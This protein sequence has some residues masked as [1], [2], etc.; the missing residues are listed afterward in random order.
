[1]TILELLSDEGDGLGQCFGCNTADL[2]VALVV[3]VL[4]HSTEIHESTGMIENDLLLSSPGSRLLPA[5]V[6]QVAELFVG[7]IHCAIW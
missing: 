6:P 7:H 2:F 3:L 1:M 4:A 5:V